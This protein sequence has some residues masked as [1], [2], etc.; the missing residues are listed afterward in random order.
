[1]ASQNHGRWGTAAAVPGLAALNKGR[2]TSLKYSYSPTVSCAPA[3]PCTVAG[4]Y[5]DAS[6]HAQG[7]LTQTR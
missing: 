5:T 4:S 6:R 2:V 1:V 3:G 7:F